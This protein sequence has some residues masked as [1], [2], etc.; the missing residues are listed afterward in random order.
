MFAVKYRAYSRKIMEDVTTMSYDPQAIREIWDREAEQEDGFEKERSL[1]NE[2]PREFIKQYLKTADVVL[3]AGGGT[4]INAIMMAQRCR[5]VTLVDISSKML[6]LAKL[7]IDNAGLADKIDLMA[8]DITALDQFGNAEFSF[9]VCV[10]GSIS[11]AF[12]KG[13]QALEALVRVAG[14]GAILIIGCDSKY[15]IARHFLRE[16]LLDEAA[17]I[18]DSGEYDVQGAKWRLYEVAEMTGML[19]KAGCEILAVASTP[20]LINAIDESLYK[21][22]ETQW[23]Q[24]KALELK[25]CTVPELLGV[26]HHLIYV[27]KKV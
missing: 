2:I 1:R 10:G 18:C 12:E 14:Q 26:G 8:G 5:R 16:G 15:G 21:E 17:K 27:A 22:D 11:F 13:Q 7:N 24:L 6:D 9:V 19:E 20:T 23:A 25:A 3:D 4:G